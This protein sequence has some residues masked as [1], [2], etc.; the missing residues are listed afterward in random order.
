M[1]IGI[2]DGQRVILN[3]T[4][5]EVELIVDALIEFRLDRNASQSWDASADPV[6]VAQMLKQLELRP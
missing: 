4:H 5:L 6:L 3:V 2:A 1:K